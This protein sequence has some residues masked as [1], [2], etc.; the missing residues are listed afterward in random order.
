MPHSHPKQFAFS[1]PGRLRLYNT[2]DLLKLPPP[3]WAVD[4]VLPLGGFVGLYGPSGTG[5]SFVAIDMAL[6]IAAGIPWQG[7]AVKHGFSL[8]VSAEGTGGLGQ[9]AMAWLRHHRVD[10]EDLG[11]N[12]AWITEAVPVYHESADLDVLFDRFMEIGRDPDFIV[13]DTLARCFEGDENLQ[14]PMGA[15]VRGIDRLR[16]ECGAT[17]VVIHH[18]GASGER[19]RGNTAFR[20]ATD[21][22]IRI[23]QGVLGAG[24]NQ[25][26]STKNQDRF[27]LIV[28][29][30]REAP[31]GLIGAGRR[32][33][34][35]G[36]GS[37]APLV[38]WME[39]EI[40]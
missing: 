15:F 30:Q 10:P 11:D 18:T 38:E 32:V 7:R 31:G 19:E 13:I 34:V 27:S 24:V 12:M 6:S 23:Q 40:A 8:Y 5:K 3:E 4:G 21:T 20:A 28:D 33:V 37:V 39:E 26:L 16:N 36:T 17:I 35:P 29:K 1:A 14:E 2:E 25:L 22:M 9:R